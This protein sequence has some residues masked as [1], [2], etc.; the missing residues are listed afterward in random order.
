M[1]AGRAWHAVRAWVGRS[2]AILAEAGRHL[3]YRRQDL[4]VLCLFFGSLLVGLG[5]AGLE[6]R[7]PVLLE[8]LEAEPERPLSRPRAARAVGGPHRPIE[9]TAP[10]T[11]KDPAAT[12][13]R[14]PPDAPL[15]LL[16]L[17]TASEADLERLPGIGPRLAR[18]IVEERERAG[19]FRAPR[20]LLRVRGLGP[21]LVEA[22]EP[23]V[24]AGASGEP[25]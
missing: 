12:T 9:R 6:R 11:V 15:P 16:D 20:E 17:N 21:R 25:R 1:R 14:P 4:A 7:A 8:R 10:T 22:L 23:L 5:V 2:G 13:P 3:V 18:R 24:T 19:P